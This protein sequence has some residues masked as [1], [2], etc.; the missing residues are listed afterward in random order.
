MLRDCLVGLSGREWSEAAGAPCGI[1]DSQE[2]ELESQPLDD[3]QRQ[4]S[5]VRLHLDQGLC[6]TLGAWARVTGRVGATGRCGD[7]TT[8]KT[9]RLVR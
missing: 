8:T 5:E 7:F 9:N 3:A 2:A 1:V 4:Y 6:T